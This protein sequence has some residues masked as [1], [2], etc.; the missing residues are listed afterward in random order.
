M[1]GKVHSKTIILVITA[2]ILLC[3][4]ALSYAWEGGRDHSYRY[5]DQPRFGM[6]IDF[7]SNDYIP[8][9]ASGTRYYYDEGLYYYPSTHGYVLVA[10]PVGAI[11]PALP[12]EY[13]P[14][15]INGVVYYTDRGIFYVY[16]RHGYQLV[17]P[18]VVQRISEPIYTTRTVQVVEPESQTK[19][20]EGMGLGGIL[21]ALTG[22]IIGHQM[23]G[24]NEVSG[25]LLGGL[26]GAAAGGIVGA[27]MPNENAS[28]SVVVEEVH[29]AV[30][31]LPVAVAVPQPADGSAD[32]SFTVNIPNG[33]GGY[34]A[35][36]IKK[37]GNGFVGPQGEYYPEFPKVSQLQVMYAK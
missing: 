15:V 35:V 5:H 20:A 31:P 30:P 10:P 12:R 8:V 23:K 1:S 7:I 18:P 29:A 2:G 6:S 14:V 26:A 36:I 24:H 32:G 27:Q 9:V 33:Q 13:R 25:A 19:V 3:S 21:G 11:V 28:R 4:P 37:S 16:T 34:V 22:G 17:P